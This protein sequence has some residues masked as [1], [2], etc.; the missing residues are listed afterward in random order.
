MEIDTFFTLDSSFFKGRGVKMHGMENQTKCQKSTDPF[1]GEW[2]LFSAKQQQLKLCRIILS[3]HH[4]PATAF[5]IKKIGD[6]KSLISKG[7]TVMILTLNEP[8]VCNI[9]QKQSPSDKKY[10]QSSYFGT[11]APYKWHYISFK[12][13]F[14]NQFFSESET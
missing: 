1:F 5:P 3:N 9:L 2:L 4:L 11:N 10:G 7:Y 14:I 8:I 13:I 12:M 6:R